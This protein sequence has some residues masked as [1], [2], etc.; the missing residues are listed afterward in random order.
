LSSAYRH[1]RELLTTFRLKVDESGLKGAIE[2]SVEQLRKRTKMII[3]F[4]Y[5]L[6]NVPLNPSEENH[7]LQILMEASQNSVNHSKGHHLKIHLAQLPDKNLEL[8]IEDDGV[9]LSSDPEKLKHYGLAIIQ[10]R[11]RHLHG[12]LKVTSV[13]DGIKGTRIE[14]TFG[15]NYLVTPLTS[16]AAETKI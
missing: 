14:L 13:L 5:N 2:K 15:P 11:S 1:L 7:L 9:G 8:L 4:H 6:N 16:K 12:E 3:D 10:E